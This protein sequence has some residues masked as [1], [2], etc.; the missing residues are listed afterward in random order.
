MICRASLQPQPSPPPP[1]SPLRDG[2]GS[3]AWAGATRQLLAA[4]RIVVNDSGAA[5]GDSAGGGLELPPAIF[6]WAEAAAAAAKKGEMAVLDLADYGIF[7]LLGK[8]E[9]PKI[10]VVVK[11]RFVSRGAEAKIK[12]VGGA[13]V[14]TA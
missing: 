3:S 8:G 13:V 14:L 7:K 1:R 5:I 9:L 4:L 2:E 12:A 11:A 6:A 10:P